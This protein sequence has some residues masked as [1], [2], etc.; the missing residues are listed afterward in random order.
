M[1]VDRQSQLKALIALGKEKGFLTYAEVND[2]LPDDVVDPEQIEDVVNMINDMGIA[3][4][5][6]APDAEQLLLAEPKVEADEDATEEAVQALASTVAAELGRTTD[7]V[8]MY[9][10]EMGTV[11]LLTREGEI[12]IAKRIEQGL[13]QVLSSLAIFPG[14]VGLLL[15]EYQRVKD[16]HGRLA[17]I[18]AAYIDPNAKIAPPPS[19]RDFEQASLA[20]AKEAKEAKEAEDADDEDPVETGPDPVEAEKRF[21]ELNRLRNRMLKAMEK[22]GT[23]SKSTARARKALVDKFLQLKFTPRTFNLMIDHMAITID[24]IRMTERAI[25]NIAVKDCDMPRKEFIATFPKNET[26][27]KW[28]EKVYRSRRAKK[29]AQTLNRHKPEILKLQERLLDLQKGT[30]LRIDELKEINRQLAL[31][32]TKARRA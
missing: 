21:K 17:D 11:E 4:H 1:T 2:H 10:R 23:A 3:V 13:Y 18:I 6:E 22:D 20:K 19:E 5:E 8:R 25:L 7:P 29:W 14:T 31:G 24:A 9:M 26:D 30:W 27:L 16:G 28:T 32:E 12:E 15:G